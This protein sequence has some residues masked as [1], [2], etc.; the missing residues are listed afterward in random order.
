MTE[1][2]A[3]HASPARGRLAKIGA[4]IGTFA[5]I[6]AGAAYFSENV[7]KLITNWSKLLPAP[8][9]A[10][11]VIRDVR[12]K[13]PEQ[14]AGSTVFDMYVEYVAE[15]KG[16]GELWCTGKLILK[17][18]EYLSV[19]AVGNRDDGPKIFAKGS[20]TALTGFK[21]QPRVSDH[22]SRGQFRVQCS[23]WISGWYEVSVASLNRL[24]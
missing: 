11:L 12:A 23:D 22:T 9:K 21:F 18:G 8:S 5:A 13:P 14:I 24:K 10:E 19:H 7:F 17:Q 15:K 1:N 6:V 20:A 16:D 3:E 4:A 2:A